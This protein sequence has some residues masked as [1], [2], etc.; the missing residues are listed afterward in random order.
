M[1]II[2]FIVLVLMLSLPYL[3]I[4]IILINRFINGKRNDF[5]AFLFRLACYH[6]LT[7]S[8]W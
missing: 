7:H 2:S 5:S 8:D 1:F 4:Q 3:C 6:G